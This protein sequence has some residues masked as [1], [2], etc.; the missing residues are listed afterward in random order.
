MR[1]QIATGFPD[2]PELPGGGPAADVLLGPVPY[3]VSRVRAGVS[4]SRRSP[5]TSATSAWTPKPGPAARR[6]R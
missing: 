6:L 3:D 2:M 5:P 1:F 4:A